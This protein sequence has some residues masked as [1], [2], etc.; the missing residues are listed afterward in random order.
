MSSKNILIIHHGALGDFV[1]TFPALIVLRQHYPSIDVLCQHKLGRL[2]VELELADASFALESAVFAPLYANVVD[3]HVGKMLRSY[4]SIVLFSENNDLEK[5]L[6]VNF[7]AAVYRIPQR[8]DPAIKTHAGEYILQALLAS[9]L[10]NPLAQDQSLSLDQIPLPDR[11]DIGYHPS[12]ILIHPGS[13]SPKKNWPINYFIETAQMLHQKGLNPEFI[14][15]P[16]EHSLIAI[17][18]EVEALTE[19]VHR[20]DDLQVLVCHLKSAGGY[21]GN[22]SGVSHLAAFLGLPTVAI[23]GPS[24]PDRWGPVGVAVKIIK[25]ALKCD[26]CHEIRAGGCDQYVCLERISPEQVLH[27]FHQIRQH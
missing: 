5:S 1:L 15:G 19:H 22:D 26:Y 23:F 11:R 17:L 21:I 25:P 10:F 3:P 14:L 16:A 27:A 2:A 7:R 24:D 8:P 9:E 12:R 18:A 20:I 4:Q 6:K 13:G